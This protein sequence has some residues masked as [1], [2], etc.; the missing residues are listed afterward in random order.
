MQHTQ[1]QTCLKH[2]FA[3]EATEQQLKNLDRHIEP[4]AR[5]SAYIHEHSSNSIGLIRSEKDPLLRPGIFT[6]AV[7][8]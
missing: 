3:G 7:F 6:L 2:L 4:G 8:L 1:A 5:V